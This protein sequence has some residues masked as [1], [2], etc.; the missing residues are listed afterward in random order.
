PIK[1]NTR[2]LSKKAARNFN[3]IY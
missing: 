1:Y 3:Y 2:V